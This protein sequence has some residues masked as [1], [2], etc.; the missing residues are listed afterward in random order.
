MVELAEIQAAYYMVAATGVLV[1]AFYYIYNV[2]T[3]QKTA[4]T[5]LETRQTQLFMQLFAQYNNKD[6][7]QD[8]ARVAYDIEYENLE[9]WTRKYG[10][11]ADRESWASWARVGRFFDGVGI[12][13]RRDLIDMDLVVDE[14]REL[15]LFSWDKMKPWVYEVRVEMKSPHTWENFEYLAEETRRRHSDVISADDWNRY[16]KKVLEGEK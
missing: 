1:A 13:V 5:T 8:F 14:L 2:R 4:R 3:N 11:A 15:I 12:L 6:F 10:S 9:D 16:A 7:M